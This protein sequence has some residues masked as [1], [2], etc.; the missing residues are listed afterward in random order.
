MHNNDGTEGRHKKKKR[1]PNTTDN[2]GTFHHG[3]TKEYEGQQRGRDQEDTASGDNSNKEAEA[4]I[5]D[6]VNTTIGI[7]KRRAKTGRRGKDHA[8]MIGKTHNRT[9]IGDDGE[10]GQ[11]R[12]EGDGGKDI[13]AR[14]ELEEGHHGTNVPTGEEGEGDKQGTR[15]RGGGGGGDG[16]MKGSPP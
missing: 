1:L 12:Q 5:G 7:N 16:E 13:Q 3:V 9:D 6:D 10:E 14:E 4:V 8:R 15:A 2:M 11:E